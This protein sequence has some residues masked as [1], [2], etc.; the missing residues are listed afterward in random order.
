MTKDIVINNLEDALRWAVELL[1]DAVTLLRD[2]RLVYPDLT[3][4]PRTSEPDPLLLQPLPEGRLHFR[5]P[6]NHKHLAFAN[7]LE[8]AQEMISY[9]LVQENISTK[10]LIADLHQ[11]NTIV[12]EVYYQF[13][14]RRVHQAR[15]SVR[16]AANL[17]GQVIEQLEEQFQGGNQQ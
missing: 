16:K 15:E 5:P 11:A 3:V 1:K 2:P 6:A 7:N 10:H 14:M 4:R 13:S 8:V 9:F 12:R 17:L